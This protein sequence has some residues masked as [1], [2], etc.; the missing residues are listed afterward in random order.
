MSHLSP[1][2]PPL[3]DPLEVMVEAALSHARVRFKR[4]GESHEGSRIELDFYLPDFDTYI[5]CK[6]YHTPRTCIMLEKTPRVIV[7]QSLAAANAFAALI[8]IGE[9]R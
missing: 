8:T 2:P 5:E 3:K 6:A 1:V 4:E 9:M 7:V